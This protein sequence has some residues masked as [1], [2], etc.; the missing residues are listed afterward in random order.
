MVEED[1]GDDQNNGY[2]DGDEGE[3]LEGEEEDQGMQEDPEGAAPPHRL[4]HPRRWKRRKL[5][6]TKY[7]DLGLAASI[8]KVRG[9]PTPATWPVRLRLLFPWTARL[10]V[11]CPGVLKLL[12][13]TF[14]GLRSPARRG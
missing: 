3:D 12:L 13:K 5:F 14:V 6:D 1:D 9:T 10:S 7:G 4:A 11:V 2:E 8:F